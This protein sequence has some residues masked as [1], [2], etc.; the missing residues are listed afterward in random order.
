M[1]LAWRMC[2]L[3]WGIIK[4]DLSGRKQWGSAHCAKY[5]ATDGKRFFVA[6]DEGFD[7]HPGVKVYDLADARQL[8]FGNGRPIAELPSGGNAAA[9][10]ITGLAYAD[11]KLFVAP[12]R[13]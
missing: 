1:L 9:N 3:G 13:A 2:E 7:Q 10:A 6:G 12:G 11:G 5:L 4:T 8:N